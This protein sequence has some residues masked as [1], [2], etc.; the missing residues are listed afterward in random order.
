[1]KKKCIVIA[2]L[3][4]CCLSSLLAFDAKIT[5]VKGKVEIKQ[6]NGTW[7]AAKTGGTIKKGSMISTGFKSELTLK[8][9]GSVIVVRPLTR[10]KIEDIAKKE[11]AVSSEVFVNMGSIKANIK[12][13]ST[14]KVKFKVKTPVATASVR[15][16]SGIISANGKLIGLTGTWAY[17]NNIGQ[18]SDVKA[19][20]VISVS[21]E[22]T[23]VSPQINAIKKA[24]V[25]EAETLASSE[26]I[27]LQIVEVQELD[28]DTEPELL[29][30]PDPEVDVEVAWE[31]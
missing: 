25:Q 19:G 14:K 3:F 11:E 26:K 20:T 7:F 30:E 21:S 5:A 17:S 24:A 1:M 23:I 22:G 27:G 10:L 16:T 15:G 18:E 13:A 29:V 4:T 8:I 9:D 28:E 12:P 31:E 6:G 2:I